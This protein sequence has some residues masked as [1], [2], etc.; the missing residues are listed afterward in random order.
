MSRSRKKNPHLKDGGRQ[1][2]LDKQ[3]AS[4]KFRRKTKGKIQLE[5]FDDLPL[6]SYELTDPWDICDWNNRYTEREAIENFNKTGPSTW[7]GGT[8]EEAII[9]WRKEFYWK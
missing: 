7:W 3:L 1:K 5:K 4:R 8:E 6:K 9:K 2:H